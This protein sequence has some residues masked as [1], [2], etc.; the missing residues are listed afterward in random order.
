MK[1][2]YL[3]LN[4]NGP[5]ARDALFCKGK[6]QDLREL[7]EYLS[8]VFHRSSVCLPENLPAKAESIFL[9]EIDYSDFKKAI[10][11]INDTCNKYLN[12]SVNVNGNEESSKASNNELVMEKLVA[13]IIETIKDD[14]TFKGPFF[15]GYEIV[16][17]EH[18]YAEKKYILQLFL[19]DV[20]YKI[21]LLN[22]TEMQKLEK[23]RVQNGRKRLKVMEATKKKKTNPE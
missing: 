13:G 3:G 12:L 21:L 8:G 4:A 11:R 1:R 19:F 7:S 5:R 10:E 2:Y 9:N 15:T 14:D 16:D 17:K 20:W 22:I 23:I 18:L 6:K